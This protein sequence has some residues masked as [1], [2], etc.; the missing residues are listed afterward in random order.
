AWIAPG[1]IRPPR[2]PLRRAVPSW[3]PTPKEADHVWSL[4]ARSRYPGAA[5]LV[6]RAP[7]TGLRLG[8]G[9]QRRTP[10]KGPGGPRAPR[11]GGR[12][13]AADAGV[14][15]LGLQAGMG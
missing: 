4:R 14:R 15:A 9:L 12:A 6:C 5:A 1:S 3:P 2:P 11:R 13:G 10:D 8:A 7:G